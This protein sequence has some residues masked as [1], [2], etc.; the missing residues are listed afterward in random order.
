[1]DALPETDLAIKNFELNFILPQGARY[2]YLYF[3]NQD[4]AL[5]TGS[6]N[7]FL[8]LG[9]KD[10]V[11]FTATNIGPNDNIRIRLGYAMS[12]FAYFIQPL[13][14]SLVFFIAF[15]LYIGISTLQKDVIEKV[16][17]SP[18]SKK[19]IPYELIQ[20]FVEQYE[21]KTALQSRITKLDEDRQKK[22]VKVKEY[23]QQRRILESKMRDIIQSL[24]DTKR[25]LKN[26]G[27][28]YA[29]AINKIE[30]SEEK[31]INIA[32]S[33]RELRIRYIRE[34]TISKDAYLRILRDYQDQIEKFER[35]IDR[36]IINLRLLLEHEK[37]AQ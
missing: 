11:S 2:Q 34:K 9:R 24:D 25:E 10:T 4:L 8:F 30:I 18:E 12:D 32:R 29:D 26:K 7:A 27:R 21:E 3:G 13:T 33:I 23:D 1:M 20:D 28:K 16:I 6:T 37:T 14:F 36:E 17:I 35:T 5:T 19:E 31:R 22:K 15:L